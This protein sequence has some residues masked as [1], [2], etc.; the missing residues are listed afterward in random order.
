MF[1]IDGVSPD[2]AHE[3]LRLGSAKLPVRTKIVSRIGE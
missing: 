3:A 1:E 2:V